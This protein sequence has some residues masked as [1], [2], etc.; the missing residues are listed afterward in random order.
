MIREGDR[1]NIRKKLAAPSGA[2]KISAMLGKR[3]EHL[4]KK[5]PKRAA[6]LRLLSRFELTR[7]QAARWFEKKE[8][9]DA[10]LEN[11]Y[12]LYEHDRHEIDAIGFWTIDRG[13][14]PD[15]AVF[16]RYPLPEECTIDSDENDDA[17]RLRDARVMIWS[18]QL[19]RV[20]I[21]ARSRRY[22]C[23]AQNCQRRGPSA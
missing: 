4:H 22:S 13:I 2:P 23:G 8:Q 12:L 7:D 20:D 6:L 11:P 21:A 5:E 19:Q 3:W 16:K 18:E 10:V 1:G 14:F 9:A 17:R 15:E